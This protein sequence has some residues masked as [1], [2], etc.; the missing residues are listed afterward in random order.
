MPWSKIEKRLVTG[1]A[2]KVAVANPCV[3]RVGRQF[4]VVHSCPWAS[5]R[6]RQLHVTLRYRRV[7][8]VLPIGFIQ[9]LAILSARAVFCG[10]S[11]ACEGLLLSALGSYITCTG[12]TSNLEFT[13]H[14]Q[15][16]CLQH[17]LL[18]LESPLGL[19]VPCGRPRRRVTL[20]R[21]WLP[22][23]VGFSMIY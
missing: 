10:L 11:V 4:H 9:N 6:G 14:E 23:S 20:I 18:V 21:T 2:G 19:V 16:I 1:Y 22:A 15:L 12:I 5:Q 13:S 3:W 7:P 8:Y 17:G